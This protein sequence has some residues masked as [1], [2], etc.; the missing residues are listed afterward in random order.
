MMLEKLLQYKFV[1]FVIQ[2]KYLFL[3]GGGIATLVAA[4]VVV[5]LPDAPKGSTPTQ[6]TGQGTVTSPAGAQKEATGF[7]PLAFFF[8]PKQQTPTGAT[9]ITTTVPGQQSQT[10]TSGQSGGNTVSGPTSATGKS[11]F[12]GAPLTVRS[13][14]TTTTTTGSSSS[15]GSQS[16]GGSAGGSSS[17]GTSGNSP[18]GTSGGGT[19]TAPIPTNTPVPANIQVVFQNPDGTTTNYVP[20]G[21]PPLEVRWGRY[22]NY[23]DGYAIDYPINW[24]IDVQSVDG[25]EGVT[26][27]APGADVNNSESPHIGFGWSSSYLIAASGPLANA[28]DTAIIADGVSG[29]LYTNGPLGQSF[30]AT[31]FPYHSGYLGLGSNSSDASFAYVYYYMLYSLRFNI[32]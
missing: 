10:T 14:N 11:N 3:L 25:H 20:P 16:S 5:S 2:Q 24:Q 8:P 15:Q 4:T 9:A 21:T 17:G 26:V 22:T 12:G 6:T 31:I 29:T 32:Q 13:G 27:Y 7:N 23:Q 19:T 28:F 1:Q 30:I 18:G